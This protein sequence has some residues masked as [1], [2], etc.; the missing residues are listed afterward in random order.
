MRSEEQIKHALSQINDFLDMADPET[1]AI[2]ISNRKAQKISLEW[3]LSDEPIIP[4]YYC[5]ACHFTHKGVK[6]PKCGNDNL[7]PTPQLGFCPRPTG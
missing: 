6:C 3:V 7:R 4:V 5:M 2:Q 1:D